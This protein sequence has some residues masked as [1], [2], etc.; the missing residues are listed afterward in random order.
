MSFP[1]S[2]NIRK[3]TEARYCFKIYYNCKAIKLREAFDSLRNLCALMINLMSRPCDCRSPPNGITVVLN[4]IRNE[5][6]FK[7]SVVAIYN[8]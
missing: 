3:P 8:F 1:L 4:V 7:F 2:C 6:L 5:F